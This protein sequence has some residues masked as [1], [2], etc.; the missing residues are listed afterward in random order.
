MVWKSEKGREMRE[1]EME[2]S[3][4][5]SYMKQGLSVLETPAASRADQVSVLPSSLSALSSLFTGSFG[6]AALP[7]VICYSFRKLT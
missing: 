5:L 1:E 3:K 7:C 2:S 4:V 6:P